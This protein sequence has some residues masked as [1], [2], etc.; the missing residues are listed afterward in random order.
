MLDRH[1]KGWPIDLERRIWARREIQCAKLTAA[2]AASSP[3]ATPA[4]GAPL[5]PVAAPAATPGPQPGTPK[6]ATPV[7]G[8]VSFADFCKAFGTKSQ[9]APRSL[10]WPEDQKIYIGS[11]WLDLD[12]R[13][14]ARQLAAE[15]AHEKRRNARRGRAAASRRTQ[16]ASAD[17]SGGP[18]E[19][20][21][22]RPDRSGLRK[23][24]AS[25]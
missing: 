25:L 7:P 8:Q 17:R 13:R 24:A 3:A 18:G 14:F 15:L 10:Q 20:A 9:W 4:T 12:V 11:E 5:T 22:G 19:A 1:R 6:A 21:G 16:I 2:A 23:L